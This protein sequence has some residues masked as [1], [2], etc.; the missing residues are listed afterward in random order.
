MVRLGRRRKRWE[1]VPMPLY[2]AL[3]AVRVVRPQLRRNTTPAARLGIL[4]RAEVAHAARLAVARTRRLRQ[5]APDVILGRVGDAAVAGC[6]RT[7]R[8]LVTCAAVVALLLAFGADVARAVVR[9]HVALGAPAVGGGWGVARVVALRVALVAI[10]GSENGGAR[11]PAVGAAA[12]VL[13]AGIAGR[14]E[15]GCHVAAVGLVAGEEVG[16]RHGEVVACV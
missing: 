8:V 6:A 16:R 1:L 13:A 10:V 3:A 15:L 14:P 7:L 4:L 2:V 5:A 11:V 9:V 12:P